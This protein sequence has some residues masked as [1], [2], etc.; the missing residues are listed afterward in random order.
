MPY[1]ISSCCVLQLPLTFFP[2]DQNTAPLT[3]SSKRSKKVQVCGHPSPKPSLTYRWRAG[4]VHASVKTV[5]DEPLKA[6]FARFVP[7]FLYDPDISA[8]KEF[9][10]LRDMKGWHT[11]VKKKYWAPEHREA[12]DQFQDALVQQFNAR[13]GT[14]P[15]SLVSWQALCRTAG[16]SEIPETLRKSRQVRFPW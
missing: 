9:Q 1:N 5:T 8:T 10:R 11:K 6:F 3:P 12:H 14:D 16:V 15:K 13:F 7:E 2:W 4:Q